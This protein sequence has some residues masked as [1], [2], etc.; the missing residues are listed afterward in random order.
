MMQSDIYEHQG[1]VSIESFSRYV[2][3]IRPSYLYDGNP[4]AGKTSSLY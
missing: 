4:D 3:F 1:G 2:E